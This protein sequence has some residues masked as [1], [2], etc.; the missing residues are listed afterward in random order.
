ME[1]DS[2]RVARRRAIITLAIAIVYARPTCPCRMLEATGS[3]LNTKTFDKKIN[4]G[5][6]TYK[7]SAEVA[8][9]NGVPGD[10]TSSPTAQL[11]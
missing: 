2:T 11:S 4:N 3:T 10:T 7:S 9:A 6:Y 1:T 5:N 8:R